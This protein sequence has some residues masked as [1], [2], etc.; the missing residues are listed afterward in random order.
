MSAIIRFEDG[1]WIGSFNGKKVVRSY[2]QK[3]VI[4]MM[5]N[6]G[7]T[8]VPIVASEDAPTNANATAED[9]QLQWPI[10]QRFNFV[11]QLVSM[12]ASGT[13]TS[14]IITGPGGLGKTHTVRAAL[15]AAGLEDATGFEGE[16]YKSFRFIKGFSTAKGLYRELYLNRESI[17]VFDD[18]DSV[19]KDAIAVN[20][21]KGALDSY[22]K[23]IITWNTSREDD[24]LPRSF[25]FNGRVIFISNMRREQ[26]DQAILT[27]AYCVDLAMTHAQKIERMEMLVNSDSFLPQFAYEYKHDAL[28]LIASLGLAVK[29]ISLRTL[30]AVVCVRAANTNWEQLATYVLTN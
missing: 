6:A 8:N 23:R 14:A 16:T 5:A 1:N 24:E 28:N 26:I 25:I 21:L 30:Q 27:R 3:R 15:E 18:C 17:I 29:E 10:N 19:L 12:I 7:H 9:T 2:D 11:S 20:L 4:R 13:A 22:D